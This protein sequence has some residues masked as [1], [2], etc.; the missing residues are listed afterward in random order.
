[1]LQRPLVQQKG[2]KL[3]GKAMLVLALALA[4][5]AALALAVLALAVALV[6]VLPLAVAELAIGCAAGVE[7]AVAAAAAAAA[8]AGAALVP[9]VAAAIPDTREQASAG[10]R[11]QQGR[12][13]D[14]PSESLC[15][16]LG[17]TS[18]YDVPPSRTSSCPVLLCQ[19][20]RSRPSPSA[21][22]FCTPLHRPPPPA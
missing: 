22:C 21:G 17:P 20:S 2:W 9:R 11:G 15:R 16:S 6:L 14:G 4:A 19:T 12:G 10:A 1:M 5:L 18:Q 7:A 13:S 8:D 3:D